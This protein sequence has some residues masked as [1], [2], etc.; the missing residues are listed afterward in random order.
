MT[1]PQQR[2]RR[3]NIALYLKRRHAF[4][5]AHPWCGRCGGVSDQIQHKAGRVGDALLD[6]SRWLAV[7][8]PCHAYIGDNPTEAYEQGWSLY[9]IGRNESD[10]EPVDSL[11]PYFGP[12]DEDGAA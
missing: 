2:R 1:T 5:T 10:H 4:L 7:C 3:R 9:R 8:G 11:L 12:E 6:E